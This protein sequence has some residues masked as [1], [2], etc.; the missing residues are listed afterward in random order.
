MLGLAGS[1]ADGPMASH[2]IGHGPED[3][4]E[5]SDSLMRPARGHLGPG[6]R[7]LSRLSPTCHS[8]EAA[9]PSSRLG[10]ASA[11]MSKR[12][13]CCFWGSG[14]EATVSWGDHPLTWLS[15]VSLSEA[16]GPAG[17]LPSASQPGRRE[18]PGEG[19]VEGRLHS[20]PLPLLSLWRLAPASCSSLSLCLSEVVQRENNPGQTRDPAWAGVCGLC[21]RARAH[22]RAGGR[23]PGD[24]KHSSS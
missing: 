8:P 18:R 16:K 11:L 1:R 22:V 9:P 13:G 15:E 20:K 19:G 4:T 3:P 2:R 6:L 7:P 5:S 24:W 23:V 14:G 12:S 21:V 10:P 17:V